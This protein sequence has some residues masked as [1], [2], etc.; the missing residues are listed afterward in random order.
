MRTST[1]IMEELIDSLEKMIDA[2]DDM[3][4]ESK[5]ANYREMNKIRDER[6]DPAKQEFK[7]KLDEYLDR[8]I[9]TYVQK[10]GIRTQIFTEKLND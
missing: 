1:E 5:Y 4:E 7:S 9:D 2:Q 6:L 3:W 8:R 10:Y